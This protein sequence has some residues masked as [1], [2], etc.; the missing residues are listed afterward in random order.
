[1]LA[2]RCNANGC[3]VGA[4]NSS[5]AVALIRLEINVTRCWQYCFH[6]IKQT[7]SLWFYSH[8]GVHVLWACGITNFIAIVQDIVCP[9]L[10]SVRCIDST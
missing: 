9:H 1:M 3:R 4:H 8:T 5:A 7:E 2:D 10:T 6:E